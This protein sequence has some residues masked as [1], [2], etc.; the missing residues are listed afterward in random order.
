M[1]CPRCEGQLQEVVPSLMWQRYFLCDE[2]ESAWHLVNGT[3]ERGRNRGGY[4]H[5]VQAHPDV[6]S[7]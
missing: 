6:W 3:L 7:V 2:C 5:Y 1:R 4:F